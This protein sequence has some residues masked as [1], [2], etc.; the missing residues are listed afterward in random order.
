MLKQIANAK[1]ATPGTQGGFKKTVWVAIADSLDETKTYT[2]CQ[3]KYQRLKKSFK[4]LQKLK[5][6]SGWGYD[7]DA[8][9]MTAEDDKWIELGK[10]YL[11]SYL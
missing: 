11:S 6:K 8:K 4:E 5:H 3:E 9:L 10:V 1:R 7:A 2:T